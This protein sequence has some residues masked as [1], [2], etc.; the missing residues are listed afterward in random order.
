MRKV[1]FLFFFVFLFACDTSSYN[2]AYKDY[3]TNQQRYIESLLD[4]DKQK[5][6]KALKEIIQCGKYLNFDIR[7]YQTKLNKLLK[8]YPQK[9]KKTKQSNSSNK[10][11]TKK[12]IYSKYI[13]IHSINP[14]RITIPDTNIKTFTIKRKNVYKKVIDIKDAITPKFYKKKIGNI[15][16]RIAQFNKNT[17]R[18]VYSSNKPFKFKYEVKNKLLLTYLNPENSKSKPKLFLPTKPKKVKRKIIV[19]DPGHGGRDVGGVGLGNRYEK[20][21][22]LK[23]AKYLKYYLQKEGYKV[24]MTRSRDVFI[25]LK[26]RTHFA[27]EK[28]ADLFVSIHC[29]IAPKHLKSP[30][31]IETYFL[32]PTRNERAIQVARLENKE[33]KG[34]NYLDQRVILNF[35]N[36]DRIIDSNKL[37][38]DIQNGMLRSLRAKYSGVK[39]GGVRPAP[40][41]VLVGTQMPAILIETG[42]LTN[43][44]EAK[45]LFNS[46]YQKR[47][48]KGIAKG[49]ANYFKKNK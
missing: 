29:N 35:L 34:L 39:D 40:F 3:Y 19:I 9:T 49:I 6:I 47:L 45:R 8:K 30:H 31:G 18:I 21:A 20:I 27:N 7:E 24:Y 25:P 14:L 22:V 43:P 23:I 13:K 48:A 2:A 4:G 42:Y 15:L 16:L 1:I 26:K 12:T 46:D 32:S 37:A 11:E 5:E 33:I 41:W 17:V 38:I 28:H 10:K 36:R 44:I